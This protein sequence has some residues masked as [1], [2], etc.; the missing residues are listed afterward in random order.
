MRTFLQ[1]GIT[2]P[3]GCMGRKHC[4]CMYVL[5]MP[6]WRM[7]SLI[8]LSLF[9]PDVGNEENPREDKNSIEVLSG[10]YF[11]VCTRTFY[12]HINRLPMA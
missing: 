7:F 10:P 3:L 1:R 5:C 6:C 2:Q 9:H 4:D 8:F 11:H 12:V